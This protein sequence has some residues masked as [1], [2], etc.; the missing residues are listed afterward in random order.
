MCGLWF[1]KKQEATWLLSCLGIKTP[2]RKIFQ[3]VL[4]CFRRINKSIQDNEINEIVNKYL[5]AG[6]EFMPEMHLTLTRFTYNDC[7]PCT[8]NEEKIQK[9]RNRKF[10]INLSK[11]T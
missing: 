1:I 6:D 5:L 3:K 10:T 4:F 2:L 9:V 7:D 11:R 8:K